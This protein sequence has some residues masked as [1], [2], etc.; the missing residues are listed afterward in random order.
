[1]RFTQAFNRRNLWCFGGFR[2]FK[3]YVYFPHRNTYLSPISNKTNGRIYLH[4]SGTIY[5]T[6]YDTQYEEGYIEGV[7]N[8]KLWIDKVFKAFSI[9]SNIN[10]RAYFTTEETQSYLNANEMQKAGQLRG[11]WIMNDTLTSTDGNT[12]NQFTR[13][14]SGTYIKTK[15]F[16]T[17]V[18][19]NFSSFAIRWR[20]RL[21]KM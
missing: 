9:L 10:L 2:Y 17:N 6:W 19:G 12:R 3:P 20:N 13:K 11:L 1:M 15:V 4:D 8:D 21:P 16:F 7:V 14:V 5:D 18:Y